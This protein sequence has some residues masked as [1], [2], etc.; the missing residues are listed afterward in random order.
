[1][2]NQIKVG[3]VLS[4]LQIAL[5]V[6]I[7]LVYTPIM[8]RLLGKAEYGLYNTV[9]SLTAMLSVLSL[10]FNTCYIRYYSKYKAEEDGQ[11]KI[12]GLNGL[13][14][15]I[16][17]I[18]GFV[19]FLCGLFLCFNLEFVFDEGLTGQE[20]QTAKTLMLLLAINLS[21]SFPMSVF[22]NIV[23]AHERFVF[24][25]ALNILKTILSPF[26]AI[27][28][29][30]LG[31]RS[32]GLVSATLAVSVITDILYFCY[33]KIK[34][35]QKFRFND[36]EPGIIK[37]LFGYTFFV[38][39]HII[40]DQINWNVDKVLLG[41]FRG[42]EET[43]V[44]S[45]GFSLYSYYMMIGLP[46]AGMF[47]PR[48]H[49]LVEET[50]GD[51]SARRRCL[52]DLLVKVAR[53]QWLVLGLVMTGLVFF[54]RPFVGFWAGE[55]YEAAYSV[56]LLL[57][58]PGT[59]DLIQNLGI[60]MQRAQNKHQFRAIVY[61]AMAVVNVFLTIFLC[62]RYGAVGSAIG[63]AVS[64]V[65]AQGL[66]INIYYHKKC[67]IDVLAF[68]KSIGRLSLG[69]LPPCLVGLALYLLLDFSS[70]WLLGAGIALYT[71]VYCL[72]V[73]LIGMNAYERSLI[74][75]VLAKLGLKKLILKKD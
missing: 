74:N 43:A 37:S 34:L 58:I 73:Y 35:K 52:T 40:V 8:L 64:L 1:M 67:N 47:T 20:Y 17:L 72:S 29:L 69:M 45:V 50:D 38:A 5:S 18:I 16:F 57:V 2:R 36:F 31:F 46:L 68:W 26:L 42:T 65:L 32:V 56:A 53:V 61:I 21:L 19:A 59:I 23:S 7:G 28:L 75:R 44:Y 63:T 27:P 22:S 4:Y 62:Q 55:G 13:F 9:A 48:V 66:I 41:R 49:F 54:G 39:L 71:L 30:L 33:V 3:T 14:L 51:L 15:L 12:E 24:L 10:G 25:K 6:I 60:E 11:K 70:I